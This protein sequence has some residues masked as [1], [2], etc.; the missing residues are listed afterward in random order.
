MTD[1]KMPEGPVAVFGAG[2]SG[3][4]VARFCEER[5]VAATI[6]DAAGTPFQPSRI[7]EFSQV[8]FSPAFPP[9]HPWIATA[10]AAG[11]ECL[12][13]IDFASLF[14]RDRDWVCVTGTN[15]KTTLTEFLAFALRRLG[16]S[17]TA[18]GNNGVPAMTLAFE[19]AVPAKTVVCETSS[20]Q[21][22]VLRHLSPAAVLW[23]NIDEDHLE[24]H[25]TLESYFRA[26]YRLVERLRDGGICVVGESVATAARE[27]GIAFPPQTQIVTRESVC[28]AV[29][30]G[31]IFETFPQ[32]ENYA[33]AL[34]FWRSRGLPEELLSAAARDFKPR[35]HRLAKVASCGNV[36]FWDDSKGTNFHAVY[37]AMKSFGDAP[38][39]WIGGGLG[40]GGDLRRFAQCLSKRL[41]GAFLIG[42]TAEEL[43]GYFE[44]NALPAKTFAT[45]AEATAAAWESARGVPA[46]RAIVLFSPGF[47]SFDMFK[48]YADR[49]RQFVS[50]V[51]SLIG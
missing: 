13:E 25:G 15:G 31:T 14:L 48:S 24:R 28:A 21:A 27:F 36:E 18:V 37:A 34:A 46:K 44:V 5:G 47:A 33:L 17:A 6:F 1:A 41:S 8:V 12:T 42:R 43:R 20:F 38:I 10:R 11:R 9:E 32:M 40:K 26:K 7:E 22:E 4:A 16:L 50:I 23:T 29:P 3:R 30:A 51:K 35:E 2:V 39:F 45:L 49:G 19:N